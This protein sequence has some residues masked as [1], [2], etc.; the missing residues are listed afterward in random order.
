MRQL[1]WFLDTLFRNLPTSASETEIRII[2]SRRLKLHVKVRRSTICSH[3][4]GEAT[5]GGWKVEHQEEREEKREGG[6]AEG[7]EDT[8]D[9]QQPQ[10]GRL[11]VQKRENNPVYSATEFRI[12]VRR[13]SKM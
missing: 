11:G 12:R 8:H 7:A 2:C 4:R 5:I 10:V 1:T 6:F 3:F 13:Q 9:E